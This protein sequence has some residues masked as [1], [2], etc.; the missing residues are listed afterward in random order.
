L[1]AITKIQKCKK[2]YLRNNLE[3][4]FPFPKLSEKLKTAEFS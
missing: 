3:I 4:L 2:N 1:L